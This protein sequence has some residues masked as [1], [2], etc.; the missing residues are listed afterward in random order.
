LG[1]STHHHRLKAKQSCRP[2]G[3]PPQA[4]YVGACRVRRH[5]DSAFEAAFARVGIDSNKL[6]LVKCPAAVF[7]LSLLQA[8]AFTSPQAQAQ[9]LLRGRYQSGR[10]D[11]VASRSSSSSK[12]SW[13]SGDA[14]NQRALRAGWL[15]YL[16]F[17]PRHNSQ[18][19]EL[20]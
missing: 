2:A 15:F 6:L 3:S 11:S 9:P 14:V 19:C 17:F 13:Y 5:L 18:G 20:F 1:R 4:H 7:P 10:S 12:P 16:L 8:M